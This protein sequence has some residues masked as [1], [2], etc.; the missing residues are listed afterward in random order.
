MAFIE[1]NKTNFFGRWESDFN[2]HSL[3]KMRLIVLQMY[4]SFVK[5]TLSPINFFL[6]SLASFFLPLVLPYTI[7][8]VLYHENILLSKHYFQVPLIFAP[9]SCNGL[10]LNFYYDLSY[11]LP[12]VTIL[13]WFSQRNIFREVLQIFL[14]VNSSSVTFMFFWML[15]RKI[16]FAIWRQKGVKGL[17]KLSDRFCKILVLSMCEFLTLFITSVP[18]TSIIAI[19]GSEILTRCFITTPLY[20]L[21]TSRC[22]YFSLFW[23]NVWSNHI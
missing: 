22:F 4:F 7:P 3:W 1:V 19:V 14:G 9:F 13:L 16:I 5:D 21:S 18:L 23:L 15:G 2:E 20:C 11:F 12:Q 10:Q 6:P 8:C 17:R